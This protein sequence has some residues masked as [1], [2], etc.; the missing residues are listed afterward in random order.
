MEIS[1]A[2]LYCGAYLVDGRCILVICL[3][4]CCWT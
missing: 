4:G 2:F 3:L 1:A